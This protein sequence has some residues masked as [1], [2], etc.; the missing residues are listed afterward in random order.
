M[1]GTSL[2]YR[3]L[4]RVADLAL[5]LASPWST[6]LA[7][8][9]RERRAALDRW[10]QW[11]AASRDPSRPLVWFHAPSVGEG[12][13]AQAVLAVLRHRHPDWQ[14]IATFFSPSAAALAARQPVDRAD[15]LPYDTA[16]NADALLDAIRPTALVFTKL[17]LWPELATRAARRGVAVA[18]VAGTVSPAS[19]RRH[20]IARWLARP[21]YR[22]LG[23]AGAISP[24]DAEGLALLGADPERIEVTGDPRFDSAL[25]RVR[26]RQPVRAPGADRPTLVAGSTWAPDERVL[27]AALVE[28]RRRHPE[29]GLILVPHEPTEAHLQALER[30]LE[31]VGLGATRWSRRSADDTATPV[32]IVDQV[33]M[34]ADLYRHAAVAFVGGAFGTAGIHSVLEPA[35]C[36]VPVVF[37]PRWQGS[38]EAGL[39]LEARA[40]R[41]L[42]EAPDQA[43]TALAE[44]W[45]EWLD[46]PAERTAAG[47]R[48]LA[49][50]EGGTG[51]AERNAALVER[52]VRGGVS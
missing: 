49:L 10:R 17:D 23:A 20:P 42:P 26:R 37:G 2:A 12:L 3:I 22:A 48:A 45:T 18:I 11:A 1:P 44:T 5:P 13:Q 30:R 47:Q 33:G 7:L 35:A 41:A 36:G 50:V 31:R 6:K 29:A 14:L 15:Y 27:I 46:H 16:P 43:A 4:A 40:G 9:D 34:L 32:I 8:G 24:A 52:V 25:E 21:G 38:R 39:L 51:A 19:G 28:V